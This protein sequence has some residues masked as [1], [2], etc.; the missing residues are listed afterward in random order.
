M[1]D[2]CGSIDTG[3]KVG[4]A[5]G[6]GIGLGIALTLGPI[7]WVAL[8]LFT[9]TGASHGAVAGAAFGSNRSDD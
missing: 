8:L 7:G 5:V 9:A 1:S 3:T 6:A 2:S 4:A